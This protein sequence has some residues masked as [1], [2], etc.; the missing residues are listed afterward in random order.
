MSPLTQGLNN[1]SACDYSFNRP[2]HSQRLS[3]MQIIEMG[4][5]HNYKKPASVKLNIQFNSNSS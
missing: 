5:G 2:K 4:Q 1:R 3:P